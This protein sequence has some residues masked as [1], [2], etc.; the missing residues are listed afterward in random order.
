MIYNLRSADLS[1]AYLK[2]QKKTYSLALFIGKLKG[3]IKY[4][5]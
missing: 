3:E 4:E 5:L 2:D 1:G